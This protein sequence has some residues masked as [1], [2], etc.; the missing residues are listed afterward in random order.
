[1]LAK[2]FTDKDSGFSITSGHPPLLW[3]LETLAWSPE[4]FALTM[5]MLARLIEIDP[6]GRLANRPDASYV[7]VL[8]PWFPQTS[9]SPEARLAVLD[10]LRERH[11]AIAWGILQRLV[12]TFLGGG[13]FNHQPRFRAWKAAPAQPPAQEVWQVMKGVIEDLIL[14]LDNSPDRWPQ[15]IQRIPDLPAESRSELY[16]NLAALAEDSDA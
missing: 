11:P 8:L 2:L 12:P 6:G 10:S 9:A 7:S 15:M 1:V 3:A 16:R 13:P 5:E 4:H 14:M